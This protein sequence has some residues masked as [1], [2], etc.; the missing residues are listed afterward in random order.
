[1]KEK[2]K[3]Q[4]KYQELLSIREKE[5]KILN[6]VSSLE[7][8]FSKEVSK[9]IDQMEGEIA[10]LLKEA[11]EALVKAADIADR[12]ALPFSANDIIPGREVKYVP[13]SFCAL[14][15]SEKNVISQLT[16]TYDEVPGFNVWQSSRS[17]QC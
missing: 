14:D 16:N 8:E 3:L 15:P 4:E 17:L 11:E 6:E 1:M 13:G 5:K 10:G 7:K 9:K 12:Y 2:N